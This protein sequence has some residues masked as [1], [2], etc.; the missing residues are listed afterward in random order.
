MHYTLSDQ[1]LDLVENA[2]DAGPSEIWID[3]ETVGSRVMMQ[4]RDDGRGM[5]EAEHERA[6]DPFVTDGIKHPGR[7]VGLGLPFLRQTAEAGCGRWWL[8][9]KPG[10]GTTVGLELDVQELDAPPVGDLAETLATAFSFQTAATIRLRRQAD[11]GGYEIDSRRLC[12]ALGELSSVASRRLLGDYIRSQ[13]KDI[14]Q[15]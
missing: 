3:V 9:S 7:T 4:V 15:R 10:V 1:L 2:V 13:E 5:T 8:T 11:S 14:W 6:V 12:E